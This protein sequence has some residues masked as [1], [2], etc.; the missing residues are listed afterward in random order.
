MLRSIF[1]GTRAARALL[2]AL[3][4]RGEDDLDVQIVKRAL[5]DWIWA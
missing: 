2:A 4:A 3:E 1:Q 5:A